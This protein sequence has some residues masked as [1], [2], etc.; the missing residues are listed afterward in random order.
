[1][2]SGRYGPHLSPNHHEHL[3]VGSHYDQGGREEIYHGQRRPETSVSVFHVG[4]QG[5]PTEICVRYIQITYA[6][7]RNAKSPYGGD[8]SA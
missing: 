2:H 7:D 1:M 4:E 6:A 5:D 8:N 3:D